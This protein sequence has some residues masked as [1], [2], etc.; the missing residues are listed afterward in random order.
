MPP[1][2]S[3]K[4]SVAR[5]IICTRPKNASQDLYIIRGNRRKRVNLAVRFAFIPL[6]AR[7]THCIVQS[8]SYS[9]VYPFATI[10]SNNIQ[11]L[12]RVFW[13]GADNF[14]RNA[15]LQRGSRWHDQ[16]LHDRNGRS[17]AW[18]LPCYIRHSRP[19]AKSDLCIHLRAQLR[20]EAGTLEEEKRE[21]HTTRP[22][23]TRYIHLVRSIA[24]FSYTLEE[25]I[26]PTG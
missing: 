16:L 7:T 10:P 5:K 11:V 6:S 25:R 15:K 22:F 8:K 26:E 9:Q 20:N 18:V 3:L 24:F 21:T 13:S 14:S 1:W 12:A 4:L 23:W 17:G 2:A 19:D